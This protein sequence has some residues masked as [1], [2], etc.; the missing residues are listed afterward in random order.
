MGVWDGHALGWGFS[1]KGARAGSLSG[2]P[3]SGTAWLFP[4]GVWRD[5][6]WLNGGAVGV[7]RDCCGGFRPSPCPLPPGERI[8]FYLSPVASGV[9]RRLILRFAQNDK[10]IFHLMS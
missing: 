1:R 9:V 4:A 5:G 10:S 7:G 2:P 3:G 6:F 8:F